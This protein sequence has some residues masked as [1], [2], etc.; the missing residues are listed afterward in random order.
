MAGVS[1]NNPSVHSTIKYYAKKKNLKIHEY[2]TTIGVTSKA[3][4][5]YTHENIGEILVQNVPSRLRKDVRENH[6]LFSVV[7]RLA[8]DKGTTP[9]VY[10]TDLGFN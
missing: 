5:Q 3:S 4:R 2:L 7:K 10:L 9:A 6:A 1:N 8:A